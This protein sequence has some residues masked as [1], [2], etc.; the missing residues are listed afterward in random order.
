MTGLILP[1]ENPRT[2]LLAGKSISASPA[3]YLS[4]SVGKSERSLA[5]ITLHEQ[6]PL[7]AASS[8][9]SRV[10]KAG[11][12]VGLSREQGKRFS[13]LAA[14]SGPWRD[15][16]QKWLVWELPSCSYSGTGQ[17]PSSHCLGWS[18][19]TGWNAQYSCRNAS[20]ETSCVGLYQRQLKARG[21]LLLCVLVIPL[22]FLQQKQIKRNSSYK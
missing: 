22:E 11:V 3:S 2:A 12:S 14:L 21:R 13:S 10:N 1:G 5:L 16:W 4:P 9:A 20:G 8:S 18:S 7:Q 15:I 19:T 6:A 17:P